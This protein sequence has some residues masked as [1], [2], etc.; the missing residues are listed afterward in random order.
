MKA[1]KLHDWQVSIAEAREIQTGLAGQVVQTRQV[2]ASLV[3]GADISARRG[4]EMAT[5][6]VV[7]MS[8]PALEIV[9]VQVIRGRPGFPYVP[10]FLSFRESP[11]VLAACEKLSVK[12]D[13]LLVDGQG[14]AHPR[15]MGL[16]CHLGLLLDMPTIGCAKSRLCG[17]HDEPGLEAGCCA[18]LKDEEEVV[19][20]A[21]RTRIAGSPVYVS[22][23]HKIGLENAIKWV[24]D[25]CRGHRLPEPSRMAHLAATGKL[26]YE[27][28]S[29]A[30]VGR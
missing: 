29:Y 5:A 21:L 28:R 7:V 4:A 25:C 24:L 11:L 17:E 20:A 9:E 19:G 26:K 10:G 30:G 12:P 18:Q 27:A 14:F 8:Y 16:A 23:G 13:L 2:E 6:A 22:I 3:A 15:R 1:Q